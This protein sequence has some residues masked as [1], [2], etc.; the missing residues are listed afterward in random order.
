MS[1][2]IFAGLCNL[3]S[4][5]PARDPL[6]RRCFS[7]NNNLVDPGDYLNDLKRDIETR[8]GDELKN[9]PHVKDTIFISERN[10][11][12]VIVLFLNKPL[13]QIPE[14]K[15]E[16]IQKPVGDFRVEAEY[17]GLMQPN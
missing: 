15:L 11:E 5:I 6:D 8:F 2:T 4:K 3:P 9:R 17:L 10:G 16:E 14:H 13:D 7:F 12:Y 1:N